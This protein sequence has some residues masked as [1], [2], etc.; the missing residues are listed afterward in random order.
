MAGTKEK[1][2]IKCKYGTFKEWQKQEVDKCYLCQGA[3]G[4]KIDG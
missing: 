1:P 4:W 2:C 3:S